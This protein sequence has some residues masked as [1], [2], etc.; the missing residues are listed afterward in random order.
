MKREDPL[1]FLGRGGNNADKI[2][3]HN[4][5]S[6]RGHILIVTGDLNMIMPLC[7]FLLSHGYEV[8]GYSSGKKALAAL[9]EQNF[10]LLLADFEMSE[11]DGLD[12]LR[13]ALNTK[14]TLPGIILVGQGSVRNAAEAMNAGAFDCVSKPVNMDE[15]MLTISHAIETRSFAR[16]S[17]FFR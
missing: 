6:T 13:D 12:M 14:P 5:V 1:S 17:R 9:R 15:L 7:D 3:T 2:E 4:E 11:M 10:D 8:S 16:N